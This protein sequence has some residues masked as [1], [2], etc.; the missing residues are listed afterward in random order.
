MSSR[1]TRPSTFSVQRSA[2]DVPKGQGGPQER[3]PALGFPSDFGLRPSGYS[4]NSVHQIQLIP[5]PAP[6][7]FLMALN[8]GLLG[9]GRDAL[10]KLK[11]LQNPAC[12]LGHGA[13]GV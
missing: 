3:A 12:A 2:F 7:R 8:A 11:F 13:Q 6:Y 5:G 1:N 9:V 10:E 4:V